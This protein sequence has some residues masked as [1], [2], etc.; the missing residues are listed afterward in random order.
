[1]HKLT[2]AATLLGLLIPAAA[3]TAEQPETQ[4]IA[5]P[6]GFF[7]SSGRSYLGVDV[8]DITSDRL[9]ALKLKEERGVEIVMV[10]QDA[11]AGKAGLKQHDVILDY[12]GTKVESE[13]QFRRMIR[14]TPPGRTATL[15]ISRDGNSMTITAQI[16]DRS[17]LTSQLFNGDKN[18]SI[19]VTPRVSEMPDFNVP[20]DVQVLTYAPSLGIQA[21]NLNQQLGEYFGVKNGEGILVKSVEKGS[22]AE[23]AGMKAGDVI[24]RAENEKVS[25]RADLRRILHSHRTGGKVTL[26]IIR[27]KREQNLVIDLPA[28]SS[29]DSSSLQILGPDVENLEELNSQVQEWG[30]EMRELIRDHLRQLRPQLLETQHTLRRMTPE[31]EKKMRQFQSDIRRWSQEFRKAAEQWRDSDNLI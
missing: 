3:G 5:N 16:G 6:D 25:D 22:A 29:E 11:P 7:L 9:S 31:L 20:F 2:F 4:I 8:R 30:P 12:N 1:M 18:S 24:T 26:G 28:R 14:E 27:D 17:K 21:E 23:K 15:G 19:V 13:E 10:D